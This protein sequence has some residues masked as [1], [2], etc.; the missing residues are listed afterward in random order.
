[1]SVY[2]AGTNATPLRTRC[3]PVHTPFEFGHGGGWRIAHGCNAVMRAAVVVVVVG[4]GSGGGGG[5]GVWVWCV[6]MVADDVEEKVKRGCGDKRRDIV[7][8][9]YLPQYFQYG[10]ARL[11]KVWTGAPAPH[12]DRLPPPIDDRRAV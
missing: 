3:R 1:M 9:T 6:G 5:G 10:D 7:P 8:R 12:N 11:Q 4:G 2:N